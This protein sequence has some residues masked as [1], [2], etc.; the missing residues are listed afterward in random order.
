M[1]LFVDS[2]A[3]LYFAIL[4]FCLQLSLLYTPLYDISTEL[5]AIWVFKVIA[6]AKNRLCNTV[7]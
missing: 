6:K 3:L 5:N 7:S 2:E 4:Q 1:N